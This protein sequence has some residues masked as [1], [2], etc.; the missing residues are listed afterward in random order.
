MNTQQTEKLLLSKIL[1]YGIHHML[2]YIISFKIKTSD[3]RL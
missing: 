2:E 1:T 3:P